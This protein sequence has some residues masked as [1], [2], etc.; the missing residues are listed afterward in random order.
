MLQAALDDSGKDGISPA[1]VCAG[2]FGS[3]DDLMDLAG[4]WRELLIKE[5]RLDYIKGY[6]AFGL[7][8]QFEHWTVE[9]RDKR[10][11]EFVTLIAQHSSKGIAFVIDNKPFNL[12]KDLPDDDGYSFGDPYVFAYVY[13]L[14]F[15]LQSLPDFGESAVDVVFDRDLI[16]RKQA[17]EAYRKILEIWPAEITQRLFRKEPHW[18]D[19]KEFLPLQAADLLAYCVRAGRDP[20]TRHDKVRNSPVFAALRGIRTGI[21]SVS[22]KQLQYMRDRKEK[23]IQR[24]SIFTLTKW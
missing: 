14:S 13:S 17:A 7:S 20:D 19:D 21:A 9:E 10:L 22:E 5:P 15:L 18:E 24:E 8:H 4:R 16:N 23:R 3:A 2:Y 6:E 12:I 1:F 11:L